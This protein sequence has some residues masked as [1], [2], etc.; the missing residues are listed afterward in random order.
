MEYPDD[1]SFCNILSICL[2][3]TN[4]EHYIKRKNRKR[5]FAF[6]G[7]NRSMYLCIPEKNQYVECN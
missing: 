4:L 2:F 5:F 7:L 6:S 3:G 1:V